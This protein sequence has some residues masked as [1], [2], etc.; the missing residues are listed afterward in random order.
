VLEEVEEV[1]DVLIPMKIPNFLDIEVIAT[2]L[3]LVVD[4]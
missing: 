4:L 1:V 3:T 2:I